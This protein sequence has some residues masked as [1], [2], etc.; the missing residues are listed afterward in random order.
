MKSIDLFALIV[1]K[2]FWLF[3]LQLLINKIITNF[4]FFTI[5]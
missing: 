4:L 3:N 2:L 1:N 5:F